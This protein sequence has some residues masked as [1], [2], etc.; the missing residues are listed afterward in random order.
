MKPNILIRERLAVMEASIDRNG[1]SVTVRH[2]MRNH[3]LHRS[4]IDEAIEGGFLSLESHQGPRGRPS[5]ILR[6]VSQCYPTKGPPG[7]STLDDLISCRHWNFAFNYAMGEIG[8]G[9]LDFKRRAWV[10]YKK[11]F[12]SARSEEGARASAS[13]LLRRADIHAAIAWTFAK[14]CDNLRHPGEE[15]RTPSEIWKILFEAKS[16]RTRWASSWV[17]WQWERKEK[18]S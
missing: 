8:P 15:P 16:D 3:G 14:Y 7:H 2:L 1:G 12:P 17:R 5:Q 9:F 13:R 18:D 11:A 10:A 4:V 6:K